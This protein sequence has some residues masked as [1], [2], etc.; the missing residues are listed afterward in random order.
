MKF[1]LILCAL[2]S[3]SS[4]NLQQDYLDFLQITP[5]P[6]IRAIVHEH[7]TTDPE[8]Q[9]IVIYLTGPQWDELTSDLES[10]PEI[11]DLMEFFESSGLPISTLTKLL[12]DLFLST[13]NMNQGV[14]ETRTIREFVDKLIA[15]FPSDEFARLWVE[16]MVTSEDFY[17]LFERLSSD[18]AY[19]L[20][21]DVRQIP[22]VQHIL[23]VLEE[24]NIDVGLVLKAIYEFFGWNYHM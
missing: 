22:E 5:V 2:L 8:Y 20:V 3:L 15:I 9:R 4:A 17:E 18:R 1:A 21:E 24:M 16:K 13:R 14:P 12:Y 11:I 10:R 6:E 23:D 7:I 19:Q